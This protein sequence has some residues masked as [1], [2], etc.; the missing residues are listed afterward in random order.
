MTTTTPP[1]ERA[2]EGRMLGGVCAGL[3]R[4]Y[5]LSATWL[6]LAFVAAALVGGIG[7]LVYL[8]GWLIVP[9]EGERGRSSA[10]GGIVVLAQAGAAA[11]GLATLTAVA[12]AA[13]VFGFG[14]AIVAVGAVILVVVLAAWG[15]IGPTWALLPLAALLVPSVAIAAGGLRLHPQAGAQRFA[16]P[17]VAAF[18]R[19]GY[20]SGLGPLLIDLRQTALPSDGT[21]SMRIDA[22]VRRTIVALPHDRCVHVVAGYRVAGLPA[23]ATDVLIG[24]ADAMRLNVFDQHAD[25]GTGQLTSARGGRGPTLRVEFASAGGSLYVRDYPDRIDPE[26]E[27]DW[28]GYPVVVEPRPATRGLSR[29]RRARQLDHWRA[30]RA[31]QIRSQRSVTA[32]LPGP[33]AKAATR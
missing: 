31:E 18:D 20:E 2:R 12:A 27:P 14:W 23:Q 33:C 11:V 24:R 26:I 1:L 17:T 13:T 25:D 9:G 22:G 16:P 6:R 8:A 29:S 10:A 7:V 32:L 3:A 19:G 5:D 15:R 21:I 4:R 30:R 28:P